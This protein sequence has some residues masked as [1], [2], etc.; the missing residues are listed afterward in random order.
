MIWFNSYSNLISF[1]GWRPFQSEA[2]WSKYQFVHVR[3]A[4][5][6]KKK[7]SVAITHVVVNLFR[8][9]LR[10]HFGNRWFETKA[11]RSRF[12]PRLNVNA[13]S[14][15]NLLMCVSGT[16]TEGCVM[17][18]LFVLSRSHSPRLMNKLD[19]LV[20]QISAKVWGCFCVCIICIGLCIHLLTFA[21]LLVILAC[22][23]TPR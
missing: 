6:L 16:V 13:W 17:E 3:F 4:R 22:N 1:F 11:D 20:S 10:Q 23:L 5:L 15:W 2:L 9:P 12:T 19:H 7:L 8:T 21:A 18:D 14:L